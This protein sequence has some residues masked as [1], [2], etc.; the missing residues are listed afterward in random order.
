MLRNSACGP[1]IG[2][3]GRMLAGLLL[4]KR[5]NRASGRPSAGRRADFGAFQVAVRPKS[6]PKA[7]VRP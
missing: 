5:R 1:K 2:L 6:S 7:H 4:G 3:T